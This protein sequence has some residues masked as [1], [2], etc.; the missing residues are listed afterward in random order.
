MI[1]GLYLTKTGLDFELSRYVNL[2]I[3]SLRNFGVEFSD[4]PH[5]FL[6]SISC[7]SSCLYLCLPEITN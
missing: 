7:V 2:R 4:S 3:V 5:D 1:E 6:C